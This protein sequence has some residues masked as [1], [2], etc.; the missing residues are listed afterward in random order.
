MILNTKRIHNSFWRNFPQELNKCQF[1]S[2]ICRQ[3]KATAAAVRSL[4]AKIVIVGNSI[5][6]END[7]FCAS[8]LG[9]LSQLATSTWV[10]NCYIFFLEYPVIKL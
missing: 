9:K 4:R 10:N 2:V 3:E 6:V 8:Q 1:K 7:H 5:L